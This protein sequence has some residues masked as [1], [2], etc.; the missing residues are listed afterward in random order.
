MTE[1]DLKHWAR[2]FLKCA[3]HVHRSLGPGFD[4]AV[5]QEALCLEL[6]NAGIDFIKDYTLP[7]CYKGEEV[8]DH[9]FEFAI[10]KRFVVIIHTTG[11]FT[12]SHS[13]QLQNLL[14]FFNL[15]GGLLLHFSGARLRAKQVTNEQYRLFPFSLN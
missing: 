4:A 15:Q 10:E 3:R 11:R 1:T 12:S 7:V 2:V 13:G 9:V 5:Y 8:G 14:Q 6:E